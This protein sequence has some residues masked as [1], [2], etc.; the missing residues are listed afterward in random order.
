MNT[1]RNIA[2]VLFLAPLL[3]LG[4]APVPAFAVSAPSE[5]KTAIVFSLYNDDTP[6]HGVRLSLYDAAGTELGQ[7]V[8]DKW[9]QVVLDDAKGGRELRLALPGGSERTVRLPAAMLEMGGDVV[10][11]RVRPGAPF[12][13]ELSVASGT[14]YLWSVTPGGD[15]KETA[16]EMIPSLRSNVLGAVAGQRLTLVSSSAS[17]QALVQYQRP[18]EKDALPA[19]WRV[20][21]LEPN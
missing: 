2:W 8:S 15:A 21:L 14:G 3:A 5:R 12:T 4:F 9:G 10:Y 18:W 19:R 1:L 6:L 11:R 17:G 13:L 7:G 20:L 16:S